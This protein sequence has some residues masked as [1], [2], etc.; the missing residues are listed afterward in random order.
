MQSDSSIR[1][2][3]IKIQDWYSV[4]SRD[5]LV[6]CIRQ[7]KI[8]RTQDPDGKPRDTASVENWTVG[9]FGQ[10]LT[11]WGGY[12]RECWAA[13]GSVL[14]QRSDPIHTFEAFQRIQYSENT[15]QCIQALKGFKTA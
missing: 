14:G 2:Q 3:S 6:F 8:E 4:F 9:V 13:L 11:S 10:E 15:T 5:R 1:A 7:R 12:P